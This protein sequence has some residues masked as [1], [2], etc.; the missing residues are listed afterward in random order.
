MVTAAVARSVI[1]VTTLT[2][3]AA[4]RYILISKRSVPSCLNRLSFLDSSGNISTWRWEQ[5]SHVPTQTAR[6]RLI[7]RL[8]LR[9]G[10]TLPGLA[11]NK[12]GWRP[13]GPGIHM[14]HTGMRHRVANGAGHPCSS[15]ADWWSP[16]LYLNYLSKWKGSLASPQH[17]N[18]HDLVPLGLKEADWQGL[19][20]PKRSVQSCPGRGP[21]PLWP[22]A[23]P[24]SSTFG[25]DRKVP[26]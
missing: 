9:L 20:P 25:Q 3:R 19:P 21:V 17:L 22:P 1:G 12:C 8:S 24:R 14:P 15:T 5:I 11:Q 6:R 16:S 13:T 10:D 2:D 4:A 26:S 18:V 23:A 7:L